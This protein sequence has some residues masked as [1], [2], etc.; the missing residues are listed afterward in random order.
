MAAQIEQLEQKLAAM[1]GLGVSTSTSYETEDFFYLTSAAQ[2]ESSVGVTRVRSSS[3]RPAPPSDTGGRIEILTSS[4]MDADV[5]SGVVMRMAT[6]VLRSPLFL[7]TELMD[8]SI[9]LARVFRVASTSCESGRVTATS[10]EICENT[11]EETSSTSTLIEETS[12]QAVAARMESLPA[13]P[14][15]DRERIVPGVCMIDN[16]SGLFCLVSSTEQVY[17]PAKVLLNSGA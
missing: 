2:V 16:R 9:D 1:V 8:S 4:V 5:P 7:A 13:Q 6:S 3:M 10:V 14:A 12:W 15:I 17:V 11:V